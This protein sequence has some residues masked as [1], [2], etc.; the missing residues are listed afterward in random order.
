MV[1]KKGVVLTKDSL[2]KREWKGCTKC[3]FCSKEE[4]IHHL[5]F[6]CHMARFVWNMLVISFGIQPP[7]S[8]SNLF[9]SW[10]RSFPS[11]LRKTILIGASALCWAI[12]LSRNDVI[13]K[14]S[15]T[16]SFLQVIFRAT[17]G[18]R[19]WSLLSK[20]EERSFLKKNCQRLENVVME[21]FNKFGWKFRNS[22]EN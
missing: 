14:N 3:C 20:E 5:F 16:D 21:I 19:C 8:I 2:V 15:T 9:G 22:V 1:F 6:E 17:Y 4:I 13:F 12:W 11:N 7:S 10:G 18:I